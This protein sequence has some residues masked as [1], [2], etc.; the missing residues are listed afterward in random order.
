[1]IVS[2]VVNIPVQSMAC[3]DYSDMAYMACITMSSESLN[4]APPILC[5]L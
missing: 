2:R 1:M 4:F 5:H 3:I